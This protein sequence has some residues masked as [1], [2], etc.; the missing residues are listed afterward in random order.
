MP[1]THVRG[2]GR[3]R[4]CARGRGAEAVQQ[5]GGVAAAAAKPGPGPVA[6][7][8][9]GRAPQ[10]LQ[11]GRIVG[12]QPGKTQGCVCAA[13]AS[14]GAGLR[15]Q[16]C[17]CGRQCCPRRSVPFLCCPARAKGAGAGV[18]ERRHARC[19]THAGA[20]RVWDC[21]VA[22]AQSRAGQGSTCRPLCVVRRRGRKRKQSRGEG[23]H[24][25]VVHAP[26]APGPMPR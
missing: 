8:A 5:G 11:G 17:G 2:A 22:R 6:D 20:G 21:L 25:L 4:L 26:Q 16:V 14:A 15:A 13:R 1:P 24:G 7:V 3:E 12:T 19:S 10:P 9:Q 18:S 23:P